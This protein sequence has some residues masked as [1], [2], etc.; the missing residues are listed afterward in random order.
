[1]ATIKPLAPYR[2]S[3]ARI[4]IGLAPIYTPN[5]VPLSMPVDN[6]ARFVGQNGG[7]GQGVAYTQ[8]LSAVQNVAPPPYNLAGAVRSGAQ[9]SAPINTQAATGQ[10]PFSMFFPVV[11]TGDQ[12]SYGG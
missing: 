12:P 4:P 3:Y 6:R 1:M 9:P 2:V 5:Y 8:P 7:Y 10:Y 11:P